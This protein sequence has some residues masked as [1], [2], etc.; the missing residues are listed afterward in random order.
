MNARI[1]G[2]RASLVE[3]KFVEVANEGTSSPFM[4]RLLAGMMEIRDKSLNSDET[5]RQFDVAFEPV[6]KSLLAARKVMMALDGP[7]KLDEL[8]RLAPELLSHLNTMLSALTRVLGTLRISIEF[9]VA[10]EGEAERTLNSLRSGHP[11]LADYI[12]TCRKKWLK[13]F[14]AVSAKAEKG[15]PIIASHGSP[16]E[17]LIEG[18]P[19]LHF[20]ETGF[21]RVCSLIESTCIYAFGCR[22]PRSLVIRE[23]PVAERVADYPRRFETA[24]YCGDVRP[25]ELRYSDAPFQNQ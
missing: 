9:I 23:I 17:F 2:V 4:A 24:L 7:V 20:L 15:E 19:A 1:E 21:D 3:W 6:M 11:L 5:R 18:V 25:W 16:E 14:L 22:L 12:E 13:Q 10:G 8:K